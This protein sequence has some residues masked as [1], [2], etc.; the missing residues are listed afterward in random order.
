VTS[1]PIIV[2]TVAKPLRPTNATG[3]PWFG[4]N[5]AAWTNYARSWITS[6]VRVQVWRS[7]WPAT[8]LQIFLNGAWPN[9]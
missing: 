3:S 2:S 5:L 8:R 7:C 1:R 4:K 6:T 9:V